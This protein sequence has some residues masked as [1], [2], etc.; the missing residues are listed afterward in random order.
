M[1]DKHIEAT[2]SSRGGLHDR[3]ATRYAGHRS[4]CGD[5]TVCGIEPPDGVTGGV[6]GTAVDGDPGTRLPS[7][8]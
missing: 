7:W 2:E 3:P 6:L 5:N 1:V 8:T 4:R